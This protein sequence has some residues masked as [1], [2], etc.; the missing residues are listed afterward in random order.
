MTSG[1]QTA[2]S[3][4]ARQACHGVD[5]FFV[6]SGFCLAYPTLANL[7]NE[8]GATFRIAA[9][10]AR[11]IVRILPPYYA[12]IATF[13]LLG[14]ALLG[15][16]NSL[17][18][19][20]SREAL[21]A[22][23]ILKQALFLDRDRQFSD[24]SFW[25]LAVEFRWYFVFP[26]LLWLWVRH[27]RAFGALAVA[28]I[29][30]GGTRLAGVDVFFLPFFM[31]GIVAAHLHVRGIRLR[32]WGALAL[33]LSLV[34]AAASTAPYG[35]GFPENGPFWGIAMFCVVVAAG[36]AP[37]LRSV[38]SARWLVA[39]GTASYGIYLIHE[40]LV[41]LIENGALPYVNSAAAFTLAVAGALTAGML[42]SHLAERPFVRSALRDALITKIERAFPLVLR[43]V[44]IPPAM[45]LVSTPSRSRELEVVAG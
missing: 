14:Y 26:I 20:M 9:Y 15:L 1:P 45:Q 10:G 25:T 11:R 31:L 23:G 30:A 38:L 28:A 21:T 12:A 3:F 4:L 6:L 24:A 2:F 37:A 18:E 16:H 19:P 41:A 39:V 44:G 29:V 13:T 36:S 27:P 5:L 34:A 42:F 32:L 22:G 33:V 17:P 8:S 40:P 35:W 43:H 7:Q